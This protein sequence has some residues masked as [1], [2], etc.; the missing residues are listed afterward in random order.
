VVMLLVILGGILLKFNKDALQQKE[1]YLLSYNQ[2]VLLTTLKGELG[3]AIKE[4]LDVYFLG[5][6]ELSEYRQKK[7]NVKNSLVNI[8]KSQINE[9]VFTKLLEQYDYDGGERKNNIEKIENHVNFIFNSLESL[10]KSKEFDNKE[11]FKAVFEDIIEDRYEHILG[12]LIDEVIREKGNMLEDLLEA[13]NVKSKKIEQITY[14]AWGLSFFILVLVFYSINLFLISPIVSISKAAHKIGQGEYDI[15]ID[16]KSND[17]IGFLAVSFKKMAGQV[18]DRTESLVKS[19]RKREQL[20]SELEDKRA[21]LIRAKEE[22][23][24][25]NQAKS[26][27]LSRMSHELRTPLNGIIGFSQLLMRNKIEKLT[28]D[29][30]E[31]VKQINSAGKHLLQLINEIL[32]LSQIESG[33]MELSMEPVS[34]LNVLEEILTLI[35]PLAYQSG[36][37]IINKIAS[38]QG[39]FVLADHVRLKQVLLNL[40]SNAIKYNREGGSVTLSCEKTPNIRISIADT[41]I[42]IP[43]DQQ[44]SLFKP[45]TR[46]HAGETEIE[47][48]GIGLVIS[49]WLIE[50][51]DGVIGFTSH[52]GQGSCFY[53]ELPTHTSS[54]SF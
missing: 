12:A 49:K 39:V 28:F 5:I 46:L 9:I 15:P 41:G 10:V 17:E 44:A 3:G 4:I 47:G 14:I 26:E 24:K 54:T 36:I 53:I 52:P 7:Q 42:G 1:L 37:K 43:V 6:G 25:A 32:D 11:K 31:D 30:I 20:I 33:N 50:L 34:V 22:A 45:F 21:D 2:T 8:K 48:T 38:Q 35:Q 16:G 27:F 40:I 51:M 23:E 18:H 29:Q 13:E 19:N